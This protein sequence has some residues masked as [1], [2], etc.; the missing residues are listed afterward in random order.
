[1]GNKKSVGVQLKKMIPQLYLTGDCTASCILSALCQQDQ[2][3]IKESGRLHKPSV[4]CG[5]GRNRPDVRG[6]SI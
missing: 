1:M 4:Q 6:S 2:P 3:E 5:A